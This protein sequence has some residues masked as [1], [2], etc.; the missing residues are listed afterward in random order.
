MARIA[1]WMNRVTL[2]WKRTPATWVAIVFNEARQFAVVT[3]DGEQHPPS[4]QIK[5]DD[6]IERQC[7]T[8]LGFSKADFVA[9]APLRL[10]HIDGQGG[11][12]LKFYFS[13]QLRTQGQSFHIFEQKIG[14][15]PQIELK[16]FIPA[17][18]LEKLK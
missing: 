6:V 16:R 8:G 14:Y 10:L 15:L 1:L 13:G 9:E 17:E 3:D 5:P 2:A 12:G 11:A 4:G 18:L 7:Y